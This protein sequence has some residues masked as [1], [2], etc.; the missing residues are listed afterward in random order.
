M[1]IAAGSD[2]KTLLSSTVVVDSHN[3][4]F[5]HGPYVDTGSDILTLF[6]VDLQY[7]G[8]LQE[9]TDWGGFV[10]IVNA[11]G[12][13]DFLRTVMVQVRLVTNE[14]E[15][16]TDWLDEKAIVRTI[17]RSI[18]RL[19][20]IGIRKVLYFGTSPEHNVLATSMTKNGEL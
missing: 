1:I 3:R 13:Y 2:K 16:W 6:N 20:G 9:Y 7:L 11:S 5:W 17:C 18:S 19:L 15:P 8:N 14:N 12:T 4:C 10:P